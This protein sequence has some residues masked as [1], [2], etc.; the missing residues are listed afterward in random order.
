MSTEQHPAGKPRAGSSEGCRAPE[1]CLLLGGARETETLSGTSKS[2]VSVAEA[3]L[4]PGGSQAGPVG[5]QVES[6]GRLEG[7]PVV[8]SAPQTT[9][10]SPVT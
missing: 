10:A 8:G 7:G 9:L 3:F 1:R 5:S 4:S 6:L 2:A